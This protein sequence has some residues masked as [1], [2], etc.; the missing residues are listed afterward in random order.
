MSGV[1]PIEMIVQAALS[2]QAPTG[3]LYNRFCMAELLP[4]SRLLHIV[5][6]RHRQENFHEKDDWP[7]GALRRSRYAVYAFYDESVHRTDSDYFI[8]SDR[9]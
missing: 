7:C 1:R 3:N 4:N 6:K 8:I 5:Y 2:E 9:L